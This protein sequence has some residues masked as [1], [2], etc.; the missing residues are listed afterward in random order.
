[1]QRK[2]KILG[3]L[4]VFEVS[5]YIYQKERFSSFIY[6]SICN[7]KIVKLFKVLLTNKCKFNCLY[8]ANRRDRDCPRYSFTPKELAD[9]FYNM[10]KKNI[11]DGL[12]LSSGIDEDQNETENKMIEVVEILRKKYEYKGYIHLKILPGVDEYL[13][14]RASLFSDRLSLNMESV[15]PFYL[16]RISKEKDFFKNLLNTLKKLS[17]INRENPLKSGI[18]TQIIVGAS[19]E[20]DKEILNFVYY[21]YKNYGITKT[22][23]SAFIPVVNTPFENRN[24]CSFKRQAFL[25]KADILLRKYGFLPSDIPFDENG[26][27]YLEKDPKYLWAEKNN[28]LFPVEIN[29]GDFYQLIRVPGIGIISA[30]KIIEIRKYCKINS[31]EILKKIGVRL[32]KALPF[33]LL[34]GKK[35][36]EKIIEESLF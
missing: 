30:K 19:D 29:K 3:E 22:Y 4:G 9:I 12:F 27:L 11:V 24:K 16:K 26:N 31:P 33:I 5:D 21:L 28:S 7:G 32:N 14:K 6:P 17:E 1:M 18:S 8:C 13:I 2:L 15:A 34:N 23:F 20:R 36:K 35:I 25:Y 10:W